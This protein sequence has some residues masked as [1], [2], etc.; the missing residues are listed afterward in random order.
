MRK[1]P[2]RKIENRLRN[3]LNALA[4]VD[5]QSIPA[6]YLYCGDAWT[7]TL[8]AIDASGGGMSSRL[9]IASAGYGLVPS[10]EKLVGYSATFARGSVDSVARPGDPE[11]LLS[12]WWEGLCAARRNLTTEPCSIR[13]VARCYPHDP[14]IVTLSPDYLKVLE[15]DL[16]SARKELGDPSQLLI[17]SAGS[18]KDGPLAANFLPCDARLQ[19]ALGGARSSLNARVL[20]YV[21][22]QTVAVPFDTNRVK[23]EVHALLEKQP[24]PRFFDRRRISDLEA[25]NLIEDALSLDPKLSHSAMLRSLR[26]RGVACEQKRFREI[27]RKTRTAFQTT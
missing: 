24:A 14:L 6:R 13:E 19:H 8:A 7:N 22:K 18:R 16:V 17:I 1:I 10:S 3:W 11:S 26:D 5:S 15:C 23:R 27:F 2:G 4:C 12:E 9:W 20:R 21:L 25:A